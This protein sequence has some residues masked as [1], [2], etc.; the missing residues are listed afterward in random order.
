M[1][2]PLVCSAGIAKLHYKRA[3]KTGVP[4]S[5]VPTLASGLTSEQAN[6]FTPVGPSDRQ[7]DRHSEFTK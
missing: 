3:L 1:A 5:P 4:N 2:V 6:S 7:P